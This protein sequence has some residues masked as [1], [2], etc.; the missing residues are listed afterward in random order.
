MKREERIKKVEKALMGLSQQEAYDLVGFIKERIGLVYPMIEKEEDKPNA[1]YELKDRV[2]LNTPHF[3]AQ[4]IENDEGIIVDVF[5]RHG[6]LIATDTY[7]NDDV[8]EGVKK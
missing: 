6:D 3:S 2:V 7:W 1:K 8:I 4:I 5:H